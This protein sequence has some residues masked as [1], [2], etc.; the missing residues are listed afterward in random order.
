MDQEGELEL[1]DFLIYQQMHNPVFTTKSP[2]WEKFINVTEER[3]IELMKTMKAT[4]KVR[5]HPIASTW[6]RLDGRLK[7]M[8]ISSVH[9]ASLHSID[10]DIRQFMQSDGKTKNLYAED[11][12]GRLLC[13]GVCAYYGLSATTNTVN[14]VQR[15]VVV[16]QNSQGSS[17]PVQLIP[18]LQSQISYK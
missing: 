12:F 14:N 18:F 15:V 17:A 7:R 10:N 13:H 8:L 2:A 9:S 1:E 16:H 4:D 6:D 11:S 3:Q 5:V